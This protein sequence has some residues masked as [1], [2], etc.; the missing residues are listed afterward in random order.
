[1][2]AYMRHAGSRV[3]RLG[4]AARGADKVRGNRRSDPARPPTA[5]LACAGAVAFT[6]LD[7]NARSR[8]C[9]ARGMIAALSIAGRS[10]PATLR[11]RDFLQL[12]SRHPDK[13]ERI[14]LWVMR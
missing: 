2:T 12:G 4:S 11:Y 5:E 9:G 3:R 6:M 14:A 10:R 13:P 1:M 7:T 8:A